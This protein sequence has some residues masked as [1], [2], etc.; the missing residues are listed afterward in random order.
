MCECIFDFLV[1]MCRVLMS[2]ESLS[3]HAVLIALLRRATW[4]VPQWGRCP[5]QFAM[6]VQEVLRMTLSKLLCD[7]KRTISQ[8]FSHSGCCYSLV[9][10]EL[11][12]PTP[13]RW[14]PGATQPL[15]WAPA[16]SV[17]FATA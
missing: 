16:F 7:K 9:V 12:L 1:I 14:L 8:L 4:P 3:F 15:Q 10:G 5:V 13:F 6:T 11:R 2:M 17:A